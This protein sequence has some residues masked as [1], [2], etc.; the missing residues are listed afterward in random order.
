M[1]AVREDHCGIITVTTS[2]ASGVRLGDRLC[3]WGPYPRPLRGAEDAWPPSSLARGMKFVPLHVDRVPRLVDRLHTL[4]ILQCM[5]Q[6][7]R[8]SQMM[9]DKP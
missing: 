6:G 5:R 1:C 4:D 9:M 2:K 8:R 3:P 7:Q